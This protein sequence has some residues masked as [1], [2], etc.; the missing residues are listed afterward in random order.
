MAGES[1]LLTCL[2]VVPEGNGSSAADIYYT[3]TPLCTS[4]VAVTLNCLAGVDW[5]HTRYI[6][7]AIF[8]DC[9]GS[10]LRLRQRWLLSI[11]LPTIYEIH[12]YSV[13][14]KKKTKLLVFGFITVRL[15][16]RARS[17][18]LSACQTHVLWQNEIIV[19]KYMNTV[20]KSDMF[21]VSWDQIS[22]S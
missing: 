13:N 16:A 15:H 1:S 20:R 14:V 22:W 3:S 2:S 6:F 19:C 9:S 17:V 10:P 11:Y 7:C 12:T 8:T 21:L 4:W 18:C 5:F